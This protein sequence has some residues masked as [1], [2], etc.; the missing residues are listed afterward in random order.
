ME[1]RYTKICCRENENSSK[2][3][4]VGRRRRRTIEIKRAKERRGGRKGEKRQGDQQ[5]AILANMKG[6]MGHL[7]NYD[8]VEYSCTYLLE[9]WAVLLCFL[10]CISY[11]S[12]TSLLGFSYS[13]SYTYSPK[14]MHKNIHS[15]S[16]CNTI[17]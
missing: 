13:N 6:L 17:K 11:D 2:I 8:E 15:R 5:R 4:H 7:C 10:L 1:N 12:V 16:I 3:Q 14:G 9:I